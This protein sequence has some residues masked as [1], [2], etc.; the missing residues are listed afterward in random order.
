MR[1]KF[2]FAPVVAI[3]LLFLP[4]TAL[5]D[6]AEQSPLTGAHLHTHHVNTPAG[7][8]DINSVA[9]NAEPRGLHNGANNSGLSNGPW[10]GPCPT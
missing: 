7:C 6:P 5:A 9:F 1:A 4:A 2:L 8:V 10:H 3:A